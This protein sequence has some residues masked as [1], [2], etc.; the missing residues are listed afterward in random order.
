MGLP[1]STTPNSIKYNFILVLIDYFIKL[2]YYYP[3]RKTIDVIQL[4][5][6]LFRIFTQ[7]GPLDNIIFNKNSIF[8]S[9]YWSTIYYYLYILY[10]LSIAFHLQIDS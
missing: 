8:I 10:K 4:T 7:I 9:K 6:L 3:V 5:K 2:I 1:K